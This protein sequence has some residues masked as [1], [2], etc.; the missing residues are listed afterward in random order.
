MVAHSLARFVLGK[1]VVCGRVYSISRSRFSARFRFLITV[2]TIT[3]SEKSPAKAPIA[4][5]S[6]MWFNSSIQCLERTAVTA[7]VAG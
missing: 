3:N 4:R 1:I 7:A 2:G 5:I 6:V